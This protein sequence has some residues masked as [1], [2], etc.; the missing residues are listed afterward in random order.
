MMRPGFVC[1]GMFVCALA[2]GPR[3]AEAQEAPPIVETPPP[4]G[5]GLAPLVTGAFL[6]PVGAIL[7]GSSAAVWN[8]PCSGELCGLGNAFIAVMMEVMGAGMIIAGAILIPIGV[9]KHARYKKWQHERGLALYQ[10]ADVRV[11]P[12]LDVAPPLSASTGGGATA[13]VRIRF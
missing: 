8:A 1:S 11:E 6:A 7:A 13:G 12:L 4:P 2:V 9:V 3:A 10:N 5:E